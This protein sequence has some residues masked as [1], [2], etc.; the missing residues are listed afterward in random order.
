VKWGDTYYFD[1]AFLNLSK[2]QVQ[3]RAIDSLCKANHAL[4]LCLQTPIYKA[5][6][7]KEYYSIP[8][9]LCRVSAIPFFDTNC[10]SID[11]DINNFYNIDHM[12]TNGVIRMTNRLLSDSVFRSLLEKRKHT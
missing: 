3:L 6:Y 11:S 2:I 12:N 9:S 8:D 7:N 4:L 5:I 1:T 10:D